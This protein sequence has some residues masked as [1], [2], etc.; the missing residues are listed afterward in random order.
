MLAKVCLHCARKSPSP[1]T[2]PRAADLSRLL[3]LFFGRGAAAGIRAFL[4]GSHAGAGECQRLAQHR[5]PADVIGE[6]QHEAGVERGA[7]LLIQALVGGKQRLV[8][9]IALSGEA[10]L[11]ANFFGGVHAAFPE[12]RSNAR[13]IAA[14]S[15]PRKRAA[16]C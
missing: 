3:V 16:T 12:A 13:W 15:K 2:L 4:A 6:Q 14:A 9:I 10:V 1:I 11:A 8:E 5:Q 7:L